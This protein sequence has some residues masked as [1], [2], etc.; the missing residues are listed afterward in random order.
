MPVQAP[1]RGH[2]FYG[3]SEKP[4]HLVAFYDTLGIRR[5]YSHLKP[6][7]PH[8]ESI[9]KSDISI[10]NMTLTSDTESQF[11][12]PSFHIFKYYTTWCFL[13]YSPKCPSNSYAPQQQQRRNDIDIRDCTSTNSTSKDDLIIGNSA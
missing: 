7:G 12:S 10:P 9:A 4:P 2:P 6:R 11:D 8:R 3:N 5:T 13:K 1:T